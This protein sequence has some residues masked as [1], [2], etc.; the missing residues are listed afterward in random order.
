[1]KKV[2]LITLIFIVIFE[3]SYSQEAIQN[4][5]PYQSIP[6]N[7]VKIED[8]F[9]LPRIEINR[10]VTIPF[11]FKKCEETARIDNF[12][13]AAGVKEGE[14][15]GKR[16][17]DSDVFKVIEGACY[18][19]QQKYDPILDSYLD[20]IIGLIAG[21]QEDDGYLYTN[22]TIDPQNPLP[23]AGEQRWTHHGSHELYNVEHMYE[24]AVAH[25]LATK[26]RT[27]LDVAI[28]NANLI[29]NIFGTGK[30]RI[31]PGHEE[32]E[33]GL[34]RLYGVTGE[35]KYLDMAKFFI[36]ERGNIKGHKLFGQYCQDHLPVVEQTEAV[37]HAVRAAYLYCGTADVAA[38][39]G[40]ADYIHAIDRIWSNVVDKKLYLTGG[41][42]ARHKGEMFGD[43]YELPNES[44]YNETCAAIG[45]AMWNYRMFLLHGESKYIDIL[46]KILYNGF[47]S[48][49]SLDGDK[50]FYPN[51]L[52]ADGKYKFNQGSCERKPWFSTS[53][54]PSNVVRFL[55]SL[56]GYIY[57]LK[58]D[59]LFVNLFIGSTVS[60]DINDLETKIKQETNYPWDGETTMTINSPK[61]QKFRLLIRIPGWAK[62]HAMPSSLYAFSDNKE[63]KQITIKVNGKKV[64]CDI[65]NGYAIIER[66][67]EDN[68][69]VNI[70]FPM[71]IRRVVANEKVEADRGYEAYQRGPI[72]YCLESVDNND[73]ALNAVVTD[74][75][76]IKYSFEPELLNGIGVLYMKGK[77]IWNHEKYEKLI[78][79]TRLTAI[80]YYA[81]ANRGT[82]SMSVW[83]PSELTKLKK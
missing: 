73:N 58:D 47:L 32:I 35:R 45:N 76:K 78:K 67:W 56:P 75:N 33:I 71:E 24:A 36:D 27:F 82:S 77:Q 4:A 61:K 21:A 69:L 8:Q 59:N 5:Y 54:C 3:S 13:V 6:F 83:L 23:K 31:V 60:L 29:C 28:K 39:T 11:D 43:D 72:V 14:F 26:K 63:T 53:C 15:V 20:S 17:N 1:M 80:P 81:W 9:W 2:F 18:S 79:E 19:L 55:P 49:V 25:Y 7:Q 68:D 40:D 37:G 38:L 52:R 62:G 41:I 12:A 64:N 46:E 16:Y 22:R 44:A 48:G 30:I 42:G 66:N 51:P 70:K 34:V 74:K 50:F 65:E 10:K 57:A